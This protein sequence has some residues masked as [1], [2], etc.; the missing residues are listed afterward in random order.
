MQVA[1][2]YRL[3]S[4]AA[5]LSRYLGWTL[6]AL[7]AMG[8][9]AVAGMGPWAIVSAVAVVWMGLML[10]L[11]LAPM[12]HD[13]LGRFDP[14]WL[15]HP[16]RDT[17]ERAARITY[18]AS[19]GLYR[20]AAVALAV[21]IL[22]PALGG[23]GLLPPEETLMGHALVMAV[24]LGALGWVVRGIHSALR[25]PLTAAQPARD[26]TT[27]E[28]GTAE[29]PVRVV[30]ET[31]MW[32]RVRGGSVGYTIVTPAVPESPSFATR[33]PEAGERAGWRRPSRVVEFDD[34]PSRR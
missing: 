34:P 17:T 22:S 24:L 19:V 1:R 4:A 9:L 2:R 5:S 30:P 14:V 12:L 29:S 28:S 8:L 20:M 23:R 11:V 27:T 7:G 6:V 32:V 21:A 31:E 15:L 13:R 18:V 3:L 33:P 25:A 26:L 10:A 16:G